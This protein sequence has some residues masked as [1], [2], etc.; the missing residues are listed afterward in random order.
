[1]SS[2]ISHFPL[3]SLCTS[4][5]EPTAGEILLIDQNVSSLCSLAVMLNQRGYKTRQAASGQLALQS[6]QIAPPDLI[7]LDIDMPAIDGY[8]VYEHLKADVRTSGIPVIFTISLNADHSREKAFQLG[9]VDYITRPF[10]FKEIIARIENHLTL[11]ELRKTNLALQNLIYLDS[12]TQVANRQ[13]LDQC[14]QQEWKRLRRE[15]RSLALLMCDVDYFKYYN[16]TYGHPAGDQCLQ[17]VAQAIQKGVKRPAD[18]V[19]RYGGE[20]F[21]IILPSTDLDGALQVA[22]TVQAEVRSLR[23][24]HAASPVNQYV[25]ISIGVATMLPNQVHEVETLLSTADVALYEAKVRGRDRIVAYRQKCDL[26]HKDVK[27]M[28]EQTI[29]A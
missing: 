2:K 6:V 21:A 23:L 3:S 14:L 10:H 25:T 5:L 9:G 20:E 1:M 16:D 8:E 12:L 7:V 11:A 15:Q 28:L 13:Y 17:Q 22:E 24:D 18:L 4:Q 27:T 19:A 26:V 29:P